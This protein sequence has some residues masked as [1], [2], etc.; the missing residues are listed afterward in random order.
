MGGKHSKQI[1]EK[2]PALSE[3]EPGF[4]KI[5][6]TPKPMRP[7]AGELFQTSSSSAGKNRNKESS[8]CWRPK[9]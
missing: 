7:I 2:I 5:P 4:E 8:C 9:K 3:S 1:D 6:L